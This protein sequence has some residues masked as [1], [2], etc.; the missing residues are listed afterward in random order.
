MRE[1]DSRLRGARDRGYYLFCG[2]RGC[3]K[4]T[5]LR[6][7]RNELHAPDAYHVVFADAAQEL[8]VNNLRYQDILLHL[9]G[10][11][12]EQL[13]AKGIGLDSAHLG[14][15]EE[16]FAERVENQSTTRD[17]ALEVKS[18]AQVAPGLL[19]SGSCLPESAAPSRTTRPTSR[20]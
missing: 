2:H 6:R 19:S 7:I 4:S 11:L 9:A 13:Q 3:G 10:K 20:S 8:D 15:M 5:E 1:S 12:V 17:F 14:K 16:W 18:G